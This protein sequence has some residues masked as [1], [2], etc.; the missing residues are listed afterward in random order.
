[1]FLTFL[2]E[3][4]AAKIPASLKEHLTLLEA[5]RADVIDHSVEQFY[6]LSRAAYVKDEGLLDRFDQVFGKVFRGLEDGRRDWDRRDSRRVA[7][8]DRRAPPDT[9]GNGE[10]RGARIVGRDHGDAQ[11][12]AR[13]AE[14]AARGRQQVDRHR[15]HLAVRGERLQPRRHPHRTGRRAARACDQGVGQA[16]VQEPRLHSRA[17]HAQHQGRAAAPA[18]L[19]PRRSGRRAR[20]RR[21][22]SAGRRRR[23][24]STSS[25]APSGTMRSRCCCSSTSA[26]RWTRTSSCARSCSRRRGPSSSTSSSSTSTT[27]RTSRCGRTTAAGGASGY[28]RWTCST[29]SRTTTSSCSSATRR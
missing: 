4:R 7:E 6:F 29:G 20:P 2:T 19:R 22:R 12:A 3:L 8:E 15:R 14:G 23:R 17:R 11:A 25:C 21:G 13:G 24:I 16:R 26:G 5:L 9:R 10:D 18:P 28:R 27:C 1:M